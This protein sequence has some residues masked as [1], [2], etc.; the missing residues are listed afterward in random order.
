MGGWVGGFVCVYVRVVCVSECVCVCV[1]VCVV[2]VNAGRARA[3][4]G[5]EGWCPHGDAAVR[6][7]E[8]SASEKSFHRKE[9]K[10]LYPSLCWSAVSAK[11]RLIEDTLIHDPRPF[12]LSLS[13]S[14]SLS[15]SLSLKQ[16]KEKEQT[17]KQKEQQTANR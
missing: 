11:I 8:E 5:R 7:P 14:L 6:I 2:C 4:C 17:A 9:C 15:P 16:K 12:S 1:C 10:R 13:L 3:Y